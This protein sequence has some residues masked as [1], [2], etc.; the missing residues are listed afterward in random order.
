MGTLQRTERSM[1]CAMCGV[2]LKDKKSFNDLMLMSGWNGTIN[3]L[4]MAT[5][6]RCFGR[7]LWRKDGHVLRWALDL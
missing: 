2:Q 7:V 5:S 4:A 3:R 1:V 6:V